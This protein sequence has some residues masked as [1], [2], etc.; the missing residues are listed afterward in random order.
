MFRQVHEG[1][2]LSLGNGEQATD[3]S[4][5][6]DLRP[7]MVQNQLS[8]HPKLEQLVFQGVIVHAHTSVTFLISSSLY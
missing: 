6:T 2:D 1:L 8:S 3:R 7:W 4:L 5:T